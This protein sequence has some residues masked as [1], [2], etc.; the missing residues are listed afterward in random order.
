M[1]AMIRT[2]E[3]WTKVFFFYCRMCGDCTLAE[4]TYICPQSGC[5]K[6]LLNGP[7]GGCRNETCEVF[8][9][10]HCFWV[11]VYNRVNP[12][13]TLEQLGNRPYLHPKNWAL[14]HTS[15][16][17]NFYSGKDHKKIIFDRDKK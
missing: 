6:N 3:R 7:C 15:S 2:L 14:D 9:D 11:R 10:R 12:G 8:P 1:T 13:T 17:I 16:W 4:S 5:P